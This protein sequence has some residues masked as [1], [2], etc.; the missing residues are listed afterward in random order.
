MPPEASSQGVDVD[1]FVAGEVGVFGFEAAGVVAGAALLVG[2][3]AELEE[4][5][6]DGVAPDDG[7]AGLVFEAGEHVGVER[8]I[9]AALSVAIR[10]RTA[11]PA[12]RRRSGCR[13]CTG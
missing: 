10:R 4:V 1:D 12:R 8:G 6:H 9:D 3:A 13:R 5:L 11:R 7:V 2:D